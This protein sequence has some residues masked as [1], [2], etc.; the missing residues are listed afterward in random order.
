MMSKT[1]FAFRAD[2][3]AVLQPLHKIALKN[4]PCKL[5]T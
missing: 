2:R 4:S 1:R 3:E 5:G